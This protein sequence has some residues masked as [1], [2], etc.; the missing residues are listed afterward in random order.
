MRT[1][2]CRAPQQR[3][4]GRTASTRPAW[5]Q[6]PGSR[7]GWSKIQRREAVAMWCARGSSSREGS[8]CNGA[9]RTGDAVPTEGTTKAA[10]RA[11]SHKTRHLE[12]HRPRLPQ[13]PPPQPALPRN[14]TAQELQECRPI[15]PAEPR[16]TVPRSP[17]GDFLSAPRPRAGITL[18]HRS[19]V[20]RQRKDPDEGSPSIF[21]NRLIK[22]CD[23]SIRL[24]YY[25]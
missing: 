8:I 11:C 9:R 2:S 15:I 6:A 22:R 19:V 21:L 7:S 14:L 3:A 16:G 13:L 24:H 4:H 25:F 10:F 1:P 5:V 12:R 20:R 17:P 23:A 18:T